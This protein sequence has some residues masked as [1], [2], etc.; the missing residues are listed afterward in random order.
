LQV[1]PFKEPENVVLRINQGMR[2]FGE[3]PYLSAL[4][5]GKIPLLAYYLATVPPLADAG[6]LQPVIFID[7]YEGDQ[8]FPVA[9]NVDEFFMTFSMYLE[10]AVMTPEYVAERSIRLHFPTRVPDLVARDRPLVE[11]MSEGR[12]SQLMHDD[13]ESRAWISSVV[14]AAREGGP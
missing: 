13:E 14:S 2:M 12:F 8:V 1:F 3:E 9:S 4:L 6:N 10:R 11:A 5:F 7:G